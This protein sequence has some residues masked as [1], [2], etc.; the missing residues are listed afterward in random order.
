MASKPLSEWRLCY[1]SARL[2]G[3]LYAGPVH[4]VITPRELE[5]AAAAAGTAEGFAPPWLPL[6]WYIPPSAKRIHEF[7]V[8]QIN[9]K[10]FSYCDLWSMMASLSRAFEPRVVDLALAARFL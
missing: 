8:R 5:P 2:Q 10:T 4:M 9:G 7:H 1:E 6:A 3:G